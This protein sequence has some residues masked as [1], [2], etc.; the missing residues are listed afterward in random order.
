MGQLLAPLLALFA[1]KV[2]RVFT[3]KEEE[4]EA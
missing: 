1:F 4:E 2:R 3:R